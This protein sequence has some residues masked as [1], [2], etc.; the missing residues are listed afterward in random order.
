M[1][2][3]Q[4]QVVF[5]GDELFLGTGIGPP[6]NEDDRIVFFIQFLNDR[7]GQKFPAFSFVGIGPV[8]LYSQYGVQ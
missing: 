4:D 5:I 6:E 3:F 1:D 8:C 2:R 7:I